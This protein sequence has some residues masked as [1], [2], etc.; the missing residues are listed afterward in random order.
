ME[1]TRA[2]AQGIFR[3]CDEDSESNGPMAWQPTRLRRL[4]LE[5]LWTARGH[6]DSLATINNS[7]DDGDRP[8]E[9]PSKLPQQVLL[10]DLRAAAR[11]WEASASCV[12]RRV[13]EAVF[14]VLEP[15]QY[16]SEEASASETSAEAKENGPTKARVSHTQQVQQHLRQL[17]AQITALESELALSRGAVQ[18]ATTNLLQ[19]PG[20]L[21]LALNLQ[22]DIPSKSPQETKHVPTLNQYGGDLDRNQGKVTTDAN[23]SPDAAVKQET[24]SVALRKALEAVTAVRSLREDL[25]S[26]ALHLFFAERHAL[27]LAQ[28][29][30]TTTP[31]TS[32][33]PDLDQ[34][35]VS[36]PIA[37]DKSSGVRPTPDPEMIDSAAGALTEAL[38]LAREYQDRVAVDFANDGGWHQVRHS[39]D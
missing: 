9:Q 12:P 25:D 10:Q 37:L 15:V 23:T 21:H 35:S 2:A 11:D 4:A 33:A 6:C 8:H 7:K 1:A 5:S 17:R 26:A 38:Q 3:S 27:A 36:S 39:M 31:A 24:K 32:L 22:V 29:V 19:A 20:T 34:P 14:R 30:A 13:A 28:A 18:A 16:C